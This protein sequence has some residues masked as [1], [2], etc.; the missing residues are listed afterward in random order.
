M[1]LTYKQKY[2]K[3]YKFKKDEDHSLKDISKTTGDKLSG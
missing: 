1:V 2:N 3:K